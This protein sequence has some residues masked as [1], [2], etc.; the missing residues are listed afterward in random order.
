MSG[1]MNLMKQFYTWALQRLRMKVWMLL[2]LLAQWPLALWV[3]PR[4]SR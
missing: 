4:T 3:L 2:L 1:K